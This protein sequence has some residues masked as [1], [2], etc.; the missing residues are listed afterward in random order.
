MGAGGD[1]LAVLLDGG[2]LQTVD[3]ADQVAPFDDDASS[4]AT[5]SQF[6]LEHQGEEGAEDVAA[7][8]R[9]AGVID[10]PGAH[11]G[12]RTAEQV[13][14]REHLPVPEHGIERRHA[15]VGAQHKDAIE[16]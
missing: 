10:R 11:L 7:G 1:A 12:L 8:R 6:L 4:A 13:L 9:I 3:I 15:G 2:L 16:V 5:V 14:D